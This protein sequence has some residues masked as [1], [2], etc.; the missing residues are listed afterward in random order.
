MPIIEASHLSREFEYYEKETG[1]K[2]SIRNLFK[3]EKKIRQAVTDVS[4]TIEP[5]EM[6]GF[7][8]PNGAGKTTTLKCCLAF[9]IHQPEAPL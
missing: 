7:I 4:F 3:R 5:G 8:G 2:G 6:V 9:S 1:L